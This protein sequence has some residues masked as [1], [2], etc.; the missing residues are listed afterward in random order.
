MPSLD[1]ALLGAGPSPEKMGWEAGNC[2]SL[3]A[4]ICPLCPVL[5]RTTGPVGVG[6]SF[7][8]APG[9]DVGVR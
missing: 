3:D 7:E 5:G 8:G 4:V 9:R 1:S 2:Q 6:I